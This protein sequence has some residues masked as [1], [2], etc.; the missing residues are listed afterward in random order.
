M[1][2]SPQIKNFL[3]GIKNF[4]DPDFRNTQPYHLLASCSN[5][6]KICIACSGGSDSVFLVLLFCAYF[7]EL[8]HAASILHLNHNLR[9]Q[10]SDEDE[11]YVKNLAAQLNIN[12]FSGKLKNFNHLPP[13]GELHD[14]RFKF[15]ENTMR[16]IGAK[17][18]LLGQQKNDIAETIIMRLSRASG[19]DGLS[20]PHE[21]Q[22]FSNNHVRVRPLL[23]IKKEKIESLLSHFEIPWRI[24]STNTCCNYFRNRVRNI[25]LRE[26][27]KATKQYDVVENFVN[28]Q[29]QIIEANHAIESLA[30]QHLP[31]TN[32]SGELDISQIKNLPTAI[33]RRILNKWLNHNKI[34]IKR[35]EFDKLLQSSSS[36]ATLYLN[37]LNGE[38]IVL[39]KDLLK[40]VHPNGNKKF[41]INWV[42]GE[43]FFP[44]GKVLNKKSII[45]DQK[46]LEKLKQYNIF[47]RAYINHVGKLKVSNF[48]PEQ[49][50]TRFDHNTPKKLKK[51][52]R[53]DCDQFLNFPMIFA[54]DKVCWIPG[55]AVSDEYKIKPDTNHALL[56]T[57]M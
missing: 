12:F 51:F 1:N 17:I 10:E 46:N 56:L 36:G 28:S 22:K 6:T 54:G 16:P 32:I 5:Q 45:F 11:Q 4:I 43:I 52:L 15:F 50:Y 18:L 27:Q 9:G 47:S 13:E 53:K 20:A 3:L 26:L 49:E 29:K 25:V 23:F 8:V 24:D 57:Y 41:E 21:I 34:V 48:C 44:N 7:P 30:E 35:S 2:L 14:L 40:I 39:K 42:Y 33:L 55:L 19:L 31:R 38:K 37:C